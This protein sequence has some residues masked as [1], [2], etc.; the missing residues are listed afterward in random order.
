MQL[1]LEKLK[2]NVGK[3]LRD[4][5]Q[6][7]SATITEVL[8]N[9]GF[10]ELALKVVNIEIKS[11]KFWQIKRRLE[12]MKHRRFLKRKLEQSRRRE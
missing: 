10:L 7:F 4:F 8:N 2:T 9:A 12:L 3:A 1:E 6:S 11:L 5:A